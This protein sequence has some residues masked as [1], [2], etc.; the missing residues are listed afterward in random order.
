M[1]APTK[2]VSLLDPAATE[3]L[4]EELGRRLR[5]GQCLA[6]RG[7][8][9]AGKTCLA[10]GVGRGLGLDEPDAVC[11]PTYLLVIEHAGRVPMLHVDAYLPAKTRAFLA[12]GGVDYLAESGGVVVVEW[13]D[14]LA[15]LLPPQTLWVTLSPVELDGRAGRAAAIDDPG[16][17]FPWIADLPDRLG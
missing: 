7:E 11:S 10:R 12:D 9:G 2:N 17:A 3:R 5:P 4:G 8:L 1:R 6:L 16:A 13:A 14:R 15:D